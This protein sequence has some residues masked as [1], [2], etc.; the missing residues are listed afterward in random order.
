MKKTVPLWL[1]IL[2]IVF[3]GISLFVTATT[4]I[5]ADWQNPVETLDNSTF[6]DLN[7]LVIGESTATQDLSTPGR[8]ISRILLFAFPLAGII[9]FVMLVWAGFEMVMGAA[10]KKSL[11]AGRQRATAAILGF[12]LLFASFWIVQ[13]LEIL[14]NV[15]IL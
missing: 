7:P 3:I 4:P 12:L 9:L 6:D 1:T 14:F 11:D 13:L 2:S 5:L 10:S 8:L 15:A